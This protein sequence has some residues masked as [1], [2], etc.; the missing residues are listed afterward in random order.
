MVVAFAY[1]FFHEFVV[2]SKGFWVPK[3]FHFA[4]QYCQNVAF[5][6]KGKQNLGEHDQLWQSLLHYWKIVPLMIF[7]NFYFD[8]DWEDVDFLEPEVTFDELFGRRSKVGGI[9]LQ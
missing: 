4:F 1:V 8:D 3:L 2:P 7:L 5:D 6:Q 9:D